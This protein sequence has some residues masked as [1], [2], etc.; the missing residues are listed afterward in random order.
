MVG[1]RHMIDQ[2]A[3]EV[4]LHIVPGAD[5][6]PFESKPR[7]EIETKNRE[8]REVIAGFVRDSVHANVRVFDVP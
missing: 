8:T 3:C 6:N 2:M 1:I 7:K 5:H 4:T